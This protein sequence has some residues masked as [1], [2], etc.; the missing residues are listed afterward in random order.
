MRLAEGDAIIP[1]LI[2]RSRTLITNLGFFES[3]D[4]QEVPTGNYG[5]SD[6]NVNIV[7]I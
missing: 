5:Y 2:A 1:S 3:V 6:I 4:L 7:P